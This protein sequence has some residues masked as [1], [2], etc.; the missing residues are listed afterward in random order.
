MYA[1]KEVEEEGKEA[2]LA[3]FSNWVDEMYLC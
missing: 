2:L 1:A 3:I